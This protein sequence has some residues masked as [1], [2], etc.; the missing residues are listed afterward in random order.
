MP[1]KKML[2][3]SLLLLSSMGLAQDLPALLPADTVLALGMADMRGV[4]ELTTDFQAEFERLEIASAFAAIAGVGEADELEAG[5]PAGVS[6]LDALGTEAWLSVSVSSFNPFPVITLATVLEPNA[7]EALTPLIEETA[8]GSEA[9]RE[10]DYTFYTMFLEDPNAPV[11]RIAYGVADD[12]LL[13]S[14]NPDT[15]RSVLRQAGGSTEAS[16]ADT[17]GYRDTLAELE[18]GDFYGYLNYAAVA[19]ALRPFAS[20]LGFDTL[21]ARVDAMLQTLNATAGVAWLTPDSLESEGILRLNQAG[22]DTTLYNL[23]TSRGFADPNTAALAPETTIGFTTGYTNLPAWWDYLNELSMSVPEIGGSLNDVVLSFTGVNLEVALF[24][25]MGTQLTSIVTGAGEVVEPGV[26]SDNLLGEAVYVISTTDDMAAARGL[27]Q[28]MQSVSMT[29]AM[30]A[31]PSGGMGNAELEV[32]D[33]AGVS[34]STYT[35]APGVT[36]SIAVDGGYAYIAPSLEALVE[37]LSDAGSLVDNINYQDS[38]ALVP[39]DAS[40]FSY[41]DNSASLSAT[42]EQLV[43]QLQL[44]A[45]IGGASNL[46]FDAVQAASDDIQAFLDFVATRVDTSVGYSQRNG[47]EIYNYSQTPIDW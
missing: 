30:F 10:G 22:G 4:S 42:A 8:Q 2:I 29:L 36:I 18:D 39:G 11:Q 14:S 47:D 34:V 37:S 17:E 27:G 41:S 6:W 28:L 38:V 25:W 23:L 40:S 15:L 26:V 44:L 31:D 13:L 45:G 9:L 33:I 1:M 43:S 20:G 12:I 7:L 35:M 16:L 32:N 21:F 24:S 3:A 19:Q 46:D 5:L